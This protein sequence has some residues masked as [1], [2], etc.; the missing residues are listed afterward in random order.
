MTTARRKA[1]CA[2]HALM[3]RQ[4]MARQ[5]DGVGL[6]PGDVIQAHPGD[7]Y[8]IV[9]LAASAGECLEARA[10]LHALSQHKERNEFE[11]G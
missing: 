10:T 3:L 11:R 8:R 4:R 9:V 6:R 7:E 1:L 2:L 5:L